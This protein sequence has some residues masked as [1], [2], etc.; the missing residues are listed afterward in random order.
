MRGVRAINLTA[1]SGREPCYMCQETQDSV[2]LRPARRRDDAT[3]LGLPGPA[4][5]APRDRIPRKGTPS[6][7]LCAGASGLPAQYLDSIAATSSLSTYTINL[8]V[9]E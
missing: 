3:N 4:P 8:F 7:R 6:L 2:F 5:I 9:T 1:V